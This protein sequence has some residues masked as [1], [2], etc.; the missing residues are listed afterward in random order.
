MSSR[1]GV[2]EIEGGPALLP[3]NHW[4]S[5]T[6]GMFPRVISAARPQDV[7]RSNQLWH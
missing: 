2:P 1:F 4:Q 5:R 6:D 7:W 3:I